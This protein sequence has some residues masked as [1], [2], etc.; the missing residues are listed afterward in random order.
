MSLDP[1]AYLA[2]LSV[3]HHR[4]DQELPEVNRKLNLSAPSTVDEGRRLADLGEAYGDLCAA[5]AHG[6]QDI[7][8]ELYRVGGRVT[9]WLLQREQEGDVNGWVP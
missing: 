3:I 9:A 2:T 8:S 6:H 4:T 7:D 1:N 5:I